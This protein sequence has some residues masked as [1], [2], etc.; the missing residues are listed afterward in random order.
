MEFALIANANH[1]PQLQRRKETMQLFSIYMRGEPIQELDGIVPMSRAQMHMMERRG[2]ERIVVQQPH[3][4]MTHRHSELQANV[5]IV[6]INF[7]G[8]LIEVQEPNKTQEIARYS[9][10]MSL[11]LRDEQGEFTIECLIFEM[12][13][14]RLRILFKH[15]S[16]DVADR[17]L[18][19]VQTQKEALLAH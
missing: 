18:Q 7:F 1:V 6:N 5:K 3:T 9:R 10:D 14:N 12:K 17:L 11:H 19:Y 15:G 4:I 16:F 13:Q 8:V 2:E